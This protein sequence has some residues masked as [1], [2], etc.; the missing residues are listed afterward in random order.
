MTTSKR[1][2]H[3]AGMIHSI[4]LGRSR[5]NFGIEQ[6]NILVVSISEKKDVGLP[7]VLDT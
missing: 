1:R 7:L 3:I 5:N 4:R 6:S 2:K